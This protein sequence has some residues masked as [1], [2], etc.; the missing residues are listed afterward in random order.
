MSATQVKL[1]LTL[2]LR[3]FSAFEDLAKELEIGIYNV[4]IVTEAQSQPKPIHRNHKD[5]LPRR[6][7]I[8]QIIWDASR[9]Y[10]KDMRHASVHRQL[11]NKFGDAEVP[12]VT[13]IRRIRSGELARPL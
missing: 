7:T 4:E 13:S 1:C 2:P 3:D 11:V 12:S 8:T 6:V 5:R 9:E 10:P